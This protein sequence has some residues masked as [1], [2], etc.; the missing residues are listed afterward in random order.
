MEE[1]NKN[2]NEKIQPNCDSKG[3]NDNILTPLVIPYNFA[4][5]PPNNY[6]F[7][8]PFNYDQTIPF[9]QIPNNINN[10]FIYANYFPKILNDQ[11][12]FTINQ[13]NNINSKN[14]N[15]EEEKN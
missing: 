12:P 9:P 13:N 4:F 14:G 8:Y 3:G 5:A 10:P 11:G 2:S 7:I 1:N 15:E 6:P